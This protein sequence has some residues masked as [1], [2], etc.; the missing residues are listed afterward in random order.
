[1]GITL[2]HELGAKSPR[3]ALRRLMNIPETQPRL[4][5][6][7]RHLANQRLNGVKAFL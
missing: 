6:V 4:C 5:D 7:F 2:M 3:A 1:M